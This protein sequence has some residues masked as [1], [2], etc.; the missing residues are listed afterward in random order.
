MKQRRRFCKAEARRLLGQQSLFTLILASLVLVMMTV[1]WQVIVDGFFAFFDFG[2]YAPEPPADVVIE[3]ARTVVTALGWFVLI[4]PL[5]YGL[6][7]IG[8]TAVTG[9]GGDHA[10]EPGLIFAAYASPRML[11]RVWR[12]SLWMVWRFALSAGLIWGMW[13]GVGL[14]EPLVHPFLYFSLCAGAVV[15][16]PVMLIPLVGTH[17]IYPLLLADPGLG[18]FAAVRTAMKLA[19]RS[20]GETLC[21]WGSFLGWFALAFVTGGVMLVLY[22]LPYFILADT[23][24]ALCRIGS[25]PTT[26]ST[27]E[28]NHV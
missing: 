11:T 28:I 1:A 15:L 27:K 10:A 5:W 25:Q 21:F 8:M 18:V 2:E 17:L 23:V 22:V 7:A 12:A 26:I 16:T 14:L 20:F 3:T 4:M 19:F 24:Y 6:R 13:Y 9:Q